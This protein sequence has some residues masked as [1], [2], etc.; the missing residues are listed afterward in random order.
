MP[1]NRKQAV[2]A[3]MEGMYQT[4]SRTN[5]PPAGMPPPEADKSYEH[6]VRTL[7][8]LA[9]H[10]DTARKW[11]SEQFG[12]ME[13]A[14]PPALLKTLVG[15]SAGLKE[16]TRRVVERLDQLDGERGQQK[17]FT[18]DAVHQEIHERYAEEDGADGPDEADPDDL[19]EEQWQELLDEYRNSPRKA[20]GKGKGW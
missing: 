12:D 8:N 2:Q 11:L 5:N 17:Q 7:R 4:G 10:H 20:R 18:E 16:M 3:D 19:S 9:R 6:A 13:D 15:H 1:R 14:A